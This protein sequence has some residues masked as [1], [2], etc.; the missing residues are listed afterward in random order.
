MKT[1]NNIKYYLD[2]ILKSRSDTFK[3]ECQQCGNCCR[4]RGDAV[5]INGVDVYRAC[6]ELK[7]TAE[8]F[9]NKHALFNIG[10]NSK[11]PVFTLKERSDGSCSLLRKG[12]CMVQNGKPVVCALYPLGRMLAT[13]QDKYDYFTQP[14]DQACPGVQHGKEYTLQAWLDK[15]H[16]ED[17][18]M[19]YIA[20]NRAFGKLAV[21]MRSLVEKETDP[22][23]IEM[24]QRIC[25]IG[26][27]AN[28]FPGAAFIKQFEINSKIMEELLK[29][30]QWEQGE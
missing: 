5:V 24:A 1:N 15:F 20:W 16:I 2:H 21:Y 8:E 3:F 29:D 14:M 19:E 17:F 23:E 4:N 13:A 9:L 26:L 22:L 6:K 27:Y 28:Y 25:M 7:C 11:L 12:K 18:D 10:P 30:F